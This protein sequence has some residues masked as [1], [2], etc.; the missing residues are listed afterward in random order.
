METVFVFKS[1][2]NSFTPFSNLMLFFTFRS[3]F[4]QCIC[5]T[6]KT[7]VRI[8]FAITAVTLNKATTRAA[9]ILLVFII[10][11]VISN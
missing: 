7:A 9:I 1:V 11:L 4:S 8:S 2:E 6:L 3:Q 5:E 10:N